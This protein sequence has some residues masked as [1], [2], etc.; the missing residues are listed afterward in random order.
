M[1]K[2]ANERARQREGENERD[3]AITRRGPPPAR[4]ETDYRRSVP[5]VRRR[6]CAA[7]GKPPPIDGGDDLPPLPLPMRVTE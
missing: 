3:R 7:P 1:E 6:P 5:R 2:R 4:R